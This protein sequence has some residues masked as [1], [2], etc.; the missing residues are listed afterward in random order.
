MNY[1]PIGLGQACT[2]EKALARQPLLDP[3]Q[4]GEHSAEAF[5]VGILRRRESGAI[6]ANIYV[7]ISSRIDAIDLPA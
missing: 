4:R 5:F 1:T 2:R 6:N 7:F 3:V